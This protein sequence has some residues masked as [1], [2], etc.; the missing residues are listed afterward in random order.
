MR[1]MWTPN[2]SVQP[3]AAQSYYSRMVGKQEVIRQTP[4]LGP[5]MFRSS[6]ASD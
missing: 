5:G 6:T 2:K 3:T 4:W 1:I